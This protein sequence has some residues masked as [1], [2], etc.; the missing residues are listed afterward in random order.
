M[1]RALEL[2]LGEGTYCG[3]AGSGG[4]CCWINRRWRG[5]LR[6]F[7]SCRWYHALMSA[8]YTGLIP[9]GTKYDDGYDDDASESTLVCWSS[10]LGCQVF[11]F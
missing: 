7:V 8:P 2:Y 9:V 10:W 3:F 1:R 11:R 5:R 6:H 4:S